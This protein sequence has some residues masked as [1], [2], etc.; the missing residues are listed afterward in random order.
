[1]LQRG[2][3]AASVR[4]SRPG[5]VVLSASFDPGWTATVDGRSQRTEI[6]APALIATT[7]HAGA[8]RI[9]FHYR[10]WGN[11]PLLF[12]L[13]AAAL[14]G[15]VFTDIRRAQS[16]GADRRGARGMNQ[17]QSLV[18]ARLFHTSDAAA[19]RNSDRSRQGCKLNG[20]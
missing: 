13:G 19:Q 15:L 11:Y 20:G 12:A 18:L 8:H 7:V 2:L 17:A 6:V 14:L 1:M 3:A 16:A 9:V 10:G 5:V 4:M